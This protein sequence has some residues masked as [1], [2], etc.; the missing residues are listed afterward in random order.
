MFLV[1]RGLISILK[2]TQKSNPYKILRFIM[3]EFWRK[4]YPHSDAN[5]KIYK[6]VYRQL[7]YKFERRSYPKNIHSDYDIC[8]YRMVYQII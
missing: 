1:L 5:I 6:Q 2:F 8:G 4:K 3:W 7:L